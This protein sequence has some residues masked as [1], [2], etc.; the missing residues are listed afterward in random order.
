MDKFEW[1]WKPIGV[2]HV[3][4]WEMTTIPPNGP[5]ETQLIPNKLKLMCEC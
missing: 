3:S 4:M 5:M 1:L 2:V